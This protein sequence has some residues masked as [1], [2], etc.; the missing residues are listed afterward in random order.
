MY[1]TCASEFEKII[2]MLFY[3]SKKKMYKIRSVKNHYNFRKSKFYKIRNSKE[4]Y[5]CIILFEM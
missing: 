4:V 5:I 3:F 2:K 1:V